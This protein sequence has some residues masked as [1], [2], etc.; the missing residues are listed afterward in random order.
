MEGR[1]IVWILKL[2]Y[3]QNTVNFEDLFISCENL[4][5]SIGV[6]ILQ[7]HFFMLIGH[8]KK[9]Y[10]SFG[11]N[12]NYRHFEWIW[13]YVLKSKNYLAIDKPF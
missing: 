12:W 11:M 13:I 10:Q 1:E 9:L 8:P 6:P 4:L 5:H 2:I 7:S 3:W